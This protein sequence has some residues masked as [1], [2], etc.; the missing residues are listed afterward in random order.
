VLDPATHA[1]ELSALSLL[2]VAAA[3]ERYRDTA[4]THSF[5]SR[6]TSKYPLRFVHAR[7]ECHTP[8]RQQLSQ[9]QPCG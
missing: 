5:F 9:Q 3:L 4:A 2:R 8:S 6:S 1:R 7:H